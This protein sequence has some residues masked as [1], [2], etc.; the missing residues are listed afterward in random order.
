MS[1]IDKIL[2]KWESKPTEVSKEEVITILKRFGFDLEFKRGSHII[3]SHSKLIN[4]PD[5]GSLGEF[6]IP[7][8]HGRSI[9]GVYL[10]RILIAIEIVTASE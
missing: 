9:K 6:T 3:V 8:K 4:Q 5:F 7:T 2:K 1:K 10:K